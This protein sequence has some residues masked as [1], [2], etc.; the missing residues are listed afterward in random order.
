ML[1]DPALSQVIDADRDALTDLIFDGRGASVVASLYLALKRAFLAADSEAF[2]QARADVRNRRALI[3]PADAAALERVTELRGALLQGV[4]LSV[5]DLEAAARASAGD[6][7]L[8]RG[9]IHFVCAQLA[10]RAG[11]GALSEQGFREA[12]RIFSGLGLAKKAVRCRLNAIAASSHQ[13]PDRKRLFVENRAV[14]EEAERLGEWGTAATAF[15]NLSWEF[16]RL[17]LVSLA[18]KYIRRALEVLGHAPAKVEYYRAVSAQAYLLLSIG[19]KSE[20]SES[21]EALAGCGYAELAEVEKRLRDP[22]HRIQNPEALT[23]IWRQRL[24]RVD[25]VPEPL[26]ELQERTIELLTERSWTRSELARVLYGDKISEQD[27]YNRFNA[28]LTRLHAR[29][30]GLVLMEPDGIRISDVVSA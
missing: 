12:G 27:A 23:S 26:P 15:S 14:A 3:P 17:G 4:P 10:L 7:E 20:A 30:P 9:E 11:E 5:P 16:E 19:R 8:W 13:D 28:L 21:L 29:F 1:H 24:A 22:K 25:Y 18:L 6:P 2:A